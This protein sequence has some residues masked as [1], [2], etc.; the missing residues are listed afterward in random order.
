MDID[1]DVVS[2]AVF[3]CGMVLIAAGIGFRWDTFMS[4]GNLITPLGYGAALFY[5]G[6]KVWQRMQAQE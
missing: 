5:A 6:V 4:Q 1:A 3:L 2:D